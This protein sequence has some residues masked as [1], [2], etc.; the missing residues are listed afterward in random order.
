MGK[1][2][3]LEISKIQKLDRPVKK[4]ITSSET[5]KSDS[6]INK[7]N[8]TNIPIYETSEF[9]KDLKEFIINNQKDTPYIFNDIYL[10]TN[11]K[12][13][14]FKK[15]IGL[16]D[17]LGENV[18]P[19]TMKPY[20]DIYYNN[21]IEFKNG[22]L[23]G[24]TVP[25]TYQNLSYIWTNQIV[26][27]KLNKLVDCIR[28]NQITLLKSGTGTGK[29]LITPRAAVQALNYQKKVIITIPKQLICKDAAEFAAK[30]SAVKIGEEI[31][32]YYKGE[33]KIS[34]KTILSYTTTGSLISKLTRS[35]PYLEEYDCVIIDEAH[36]RSV[37][38]DL[39]LFFLKR[40]CIK[41]PE[42]KLVIMSA[43]VDLQS[44]Y[45]YF[46][47]GEQTQN[48]INDI[49]KATFKFDEIDVGSEKIFKVEPIF[50]DKPIS[51]NEW[52]KLAA[53]K[54]ADILKNTQ[55]GDIMIFV[56]APGEGEEI[57]RY[58]NQEVKTFSNMK[59]FCIHLS[60]STSKGNDKK[61][62]KGELPITNHPNYDPENPF[63][64]RIIMATNVAES[65]ITIDSVVYVI[66]S[67]YQYE[68]SYYPET[69]ARKLIENRISKS[70]SIQRAG[71]A[72][73]TQDGFC[74]YLYTKE[75]QEKF[76][77]FPTPDIRKKD[78][79]NTILDLFSLPYVSNVGDI[80]NN[81]LQK[82]I[83]PPE[84]VFFKS[85]I[86]NLYALKAIDSEENNGIRTDLGM[87]ISNFRAV[88]AHIAKCIVA[89]YYYR[90]KYDVMSIIAIFINL[91]DG[92]IEYL[93]DDY[94]PK[95]INKNNTQ[96]VER[97]LS[98]LESKK[99]RFYSA[100]GD[101]MT[102]YNVYSDFRDFMNSA[103]RSEEEINRWYSD[104]A[105]KKGVFT[106]K[107]KNGIM[108]DK[109]KDLVFKYN[110][111]L[112]KVVQPPELKKKYFNELKKEN[113]NISIQSINKEIKQNENI[114]TPFE[115]INIEEINVNNKLTDTQTGGYSAKPYEI[116]FF[117]NAVPFEKKED[118]ITMSLAHGLI[119]N[120]AK[121]KNSK[122]GIY[123]TCF[124][125]KK[126]DCRIDRNTSLK[127][128]TK[129]AML[130]Y[131]ELFQMREDQPILKL[132]FVNRL[133][134]VVMDQLKI[135]YTDLLK[136][137]SKKTK[138]NDNKK[139][140]GKKDYKDY[141]KSSKKSKYKYYSS[142]KKYQKSK[143]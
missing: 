11:E 37:E 96:A 93:F 15:P 3:K 123:K 55:D 44:F 59:P 107:E 106:K 45:N 133:S 22:P 131:G 24:I 76:Q 95:W 80:Y 18:N 103:N 9:K 143:K 138:N 48:N 117:P 20:E 87:G 70:A 134:K 119:I 122:Q 23:K 100:Y 62:A 88:P 82:L 136:E 27:K 72:G 63:T 17:P 85:A 124:P 29:T 126:V 118:N 68:D 77:E 30:C 94:V 32:Y 6:N 89:S 4:K 42:L 28:E 61:L 125:I 58:I 139:N 10:N 60:S 38:T 5:I 115:K 25:M 16:Y 52:K 8:N 19:F 73:R 56:A 66:D 105:I 130:M 54:T 108:K 113:K 64:R 92:R 112:N 51:E 31:G 129:P 57:C 65:S 104:N 67:G 111:L 26:Y 21:K 121:L 34:E 140:Y 137:Y 90:C 127:S 97:Y 1:S 83:S 78:L 49:S 75:E 35:D 128:K 141:K 120:M 41:R 116:N 142:K 132:N 36:E 14:V 101:F 91:L 39:L 40:A 109:V 79:T 53:K 102:V 33:R 98:E 135:D 81:V 74:Y 43:T 84:N 2:K 47:K 99:K 69:N 86:N 46:P 71:R 50:L 114:S 13:S 12:I 7:N 110:I